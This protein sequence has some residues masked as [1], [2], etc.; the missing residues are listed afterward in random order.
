MQQALLPMLSRHLLRLDRVYHSNCSKQLPACQQGVRV[1]AFVDSLTSSRLALCLKLP[2][3]SHS[4]RPTTRLTNPSAKIIDKMA[5]SVLLAVA[6]LLRNSFLVF[7]LI[8]PQV[9]ADD[10]H[11][12]CYWPNGDVSPKDS[13]CASAGRPS[14]CCPVG[15][16]RLTN[17]LCY[18]ELAK[19]Y[20]RTSCTDRTWEDMTCLDMCTKSKIF[21]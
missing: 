15:W 21:L 9:S 7:L 18:N 6:P 17:N 2:V 11:D 3:H 19:I 20:E 10:L 14:A 5:L 8:T 4:C 13:V 16:Q 12:T 1:S